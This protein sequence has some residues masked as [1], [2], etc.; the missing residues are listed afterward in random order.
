MTSEVEERPRLVTG[1]YGRHRRQW[2]KF[3]GRNSALRHKREENTRIFPF[4]TQYRPSVPN[5][6]QILMQKWHLIQQQP[7]L[8]KILKDPPIV[9]Y[10]RGR[11]L[12]VHSLEQNFDWLLDVDGSC[13]GLS[14][15]IITVDLYQT[16][17]VPSRAST[18]FTQI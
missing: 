4:L 2:V 13:A 6:K 8:R 14:P 16:G 1:G 11:S 18:N 7:L 9:S 15:F 10:K 5:L 12:K 3:E 17:P